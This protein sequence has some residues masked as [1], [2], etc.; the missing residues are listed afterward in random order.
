MAQEVVYPLGRP[1]RCSYSVSNVSPTVEDTI[2]I[3][4]TMVNDAAYSFSGLY[5]SD[6]LP[7]EFS[8]ISSS[9]SINSTPITARMTGPIADE[10]IVGYNSYHWVINDPLGWPTN[11]LA[12]ADSFHF[13]MIVTCTT[14]GEYMLD[15][16]TGSAFGDNSGLFF[17]PSSPISISV[18]EIVVSV[19][20]DEEDELVAIESLRSWGYNNPFN[21]VATIA[22]AGSG[23]GGKTI[24]L[25]VYNILGR[26][27][28]R[29]QGIAVANEGNIR[30]NA[31]NVGSGMYFYRLSIGESQSFGKLLLLK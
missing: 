21:A 10:L 12:P 19:D 27:V 6:Y 24:N 8:V 9:L 26:T 30:W 23:I 13:E 11:I 17:L 22:Y 18:S 1:L 25:V 28:H 5:L 2:T 29:T 3:T 14:D 7:A 16:H 4:R 20:S 15:F 31:E